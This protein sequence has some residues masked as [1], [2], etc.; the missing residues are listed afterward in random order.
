MDNLAV[1]YLSAPTAANLYVFGWVLSAA[2]GYGYYGP[3]VFDNS[4]YR[5]FW[6][7]GVVSPLVRSSSN[8][9][10]VLS[11]P[12]LMVCSSYPPP[13]VLPLVRLSLLFSYS[14]SIV[15]CLCFLFHFTFPLALGL[16][17]IA[18][19]RPKRELALIS[20]HSIFFPTRRPHP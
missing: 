7:Y 16:K 12:V 11:V 3:D 20:T 9:N 15:P 8:P 13:A 19:S 10:T 2:D 1:S 14:S 6:L 17:N 18:R 5:H 4:I